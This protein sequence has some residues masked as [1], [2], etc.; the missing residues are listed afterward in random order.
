MSSCP[1]TSFGYTNA[2]DDASLA[3]LRD[4]RTCGVTDGQALVFSSTYNSWIPGAAGST[5]VKYL[6]TQEFIS[7]G[8]YTPT[9]GTTF[10][11][12]HAWGAGGSGGGFVGGANYSFGGVG[13]RG[14]FVKAI[15]NLPTGAGTLTVP[16]TT[17]GN[18]GLAGSAG[19]NSEV[20]FASGESVIATG[21]GGGEI[22]TIAATS[23]DIAFARAGQPGRCTVSGFQKIYG[24]DVTGTNRHL[25]PPTQVFRDGSFIAPCAPALMKSDG[26]LNTGY[27][28]SVGPGETNGQF[29]TAPGVGGPAS[30]QTNGELTDSPGGTGGQGRVLIVEYGSN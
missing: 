17:S 22:E 18:S 4:V 6:N 23:T 26:N 21:G 28:T 15:G 30:V 9:T 14:G 3:G 27:E 11:E 10:I 19:G 13:G 29:N 7:S 20:T 2:Y 16:N 12:I 25:H 24:S 8:A 1:K 5:S